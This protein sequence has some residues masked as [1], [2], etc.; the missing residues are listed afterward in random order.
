MAELKAQIEI[1]NLSDLQKLVDEANEILLKI[2]TF[3][4][5][6]KLGESADGDHPEELAK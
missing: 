3:Q 1:I 6:I 2:S 4:A 5:Q